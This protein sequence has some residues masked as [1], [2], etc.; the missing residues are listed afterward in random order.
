MR[1]N[2]AIYI[3]ALTP[4]FNKEAV[5]QFNKFDKEYS[6]YLH[7]SLML[8]HNELLKNFK[9]ILPV[10]YFIDEKDKDFL[11]VEFHDSKIIFRESGNP[12]L[13]TNILREKYFSATNKNLIILSNSIGFTSAIIKKIFD[14]L[15]V[16]DNVV[17]IGKAYNNKVSFI[18]FNSN[19]LEIFQ[20]INWCKPDFDSLLAKA[21]KGENYI[22]VL[23][24]FMIMNDAEDFK[25]LYNELSKKES[26]SYCSHSMHER[27]T[28]LFI[29]YKDLLK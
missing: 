23:E 11:P 6:S 27:F 20:G 13:I 3:I 9:S 25:L 19:Q 21:C 10:V 4:H 29:E 22:Y 8:N 7:S 28:N 1:H 16:E 24:N 15:L 17:V 18:G 5:I 12:N 14:L 26:L 2:S